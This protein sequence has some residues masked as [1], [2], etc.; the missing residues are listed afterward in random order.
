MIKTFIGLEITP[1]R[2]EKNQNTAPYYKK[3]TSFAM[4]IFGK[5]WRNFATQFSIYIYD[6]TPRVLHF[7]KTFSNFVVSGWR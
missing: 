6:N 3:E 7:A 1:L 5:V 2:P 4:L